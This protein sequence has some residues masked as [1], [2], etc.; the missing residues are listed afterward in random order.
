MISVKRPFSTINWQSR[1]SGN[2]KAQ[3]YIPN[4]IIIDIR[5]NGATTQRSEDDQSLR[6][7]KPKRNR[8]TAA[9]P[10]QR[11]TTANRYIIIMIITILIMII[12]KRTPALQCTNTYNN[13]NN[14]ND[15]NNNYDTSCSHSRARDPP[16]R[17]HPYR[18]PLR[19]HDREALPPFP[20]PRPPPACR[21]PVR[22]FRVGIPMRLPPLQWRHDA[23]T[24]TT[25]T[26]KGGRCVRVWYAVVVPWMDQGFSTS[27]E[28]YLVQ[29]VLPIHRNHS[30][31]QG[32]RSVLNTGKN[33][34]FLNRN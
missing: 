26:A 10:E 27:V 23:G 18:N 9:I 21:H 34:L 12:I 3:R 19:R 17:W 33:H 7:E 5:R 25:A 11:V 31:I 4:H 8:L 30:V 22:R 20:A 1:H 13:K 14:D 2:I 15:I 16:P 6:K 29:N 24:T 28:A 32:S